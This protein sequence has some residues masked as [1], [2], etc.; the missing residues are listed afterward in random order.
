[1]KRLAASPEINIRLLYNIPARPDLLTVGIE[2]VWALA[3]KMYR[4][5]IDRHRGLN[6]PY[7]HMGMV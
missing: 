2:R 3:K 5:D 6:R 4:D 1:M 7:D